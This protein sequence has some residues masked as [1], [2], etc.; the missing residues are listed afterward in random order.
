MGEILACKS[1]ILAQFI[2]ILAF[3]V[4]AQTENVLSIELIDQRILTLRDAGSGDEDETLKAYQSARGLL[5]AAASH[6]REAQEYLDA[7]TNA[8]IREAEILARVDALSEESTPLNFEGLSLNELE[9]KK[10]LLNNKLTNAKDAFDV[11]EKRFSNR[12]KNVLAI[13]QRLSE[14]AE[15]IT[16]LPDEPLIINRDD[17]TS[18]NEASNWVQYCERI[19]LR[20]ERKAQELR[21]DSQSERYSVLQAQRAELKLQIDLFI[22]QLKAVE[23]KISEA[24]LSAFDIS[25]TDIDSHSPIYKIAENII[26]ARSLFRQ[27]RKDL[28]EEKRIIVKKNERLEKQLNAISERLASLRRVVDYA[29]SSEILSSVLIAHWRETESFKLKDPTRELSSTIGDIVI[30]RID[31]EKEESTLF[32][33]RAYVANL[34]ETQK[35]DPELITDE[36]RNSLTN[37]VRSKRTELHELIDEESEYIELLRNHIQIY[38]QLKSLNNEYKNFISSRILWAASHKNI[39]INDF[40]KIPKELKFIYSELTNLRIEKFPFITLLGL[41][42]AIILYLL[43]KHFITYMAKLNKNVATVRND[44]ILFTVNASALTILRALPL[45][46]VFWSL[47]IDFADWEETIFHVLSTRLDLLA[48]IVLILLTIRI[49]CEE[50]GIGLK[51]FGWYKNTTTAAIQE[52]N[53]WLRWWVPLAIIGIIINSLQVDLY[54][55]ITDQLISLLL[56]LLIAWHLFRSLKRDK[57]PEQSVINVLKEHRLKSMFFLLVVIILI[58]LASG[59][60]FT[61][62]KF[63]ET[64][65]YTFIAVIFLV[66]LYN[67]LKR[68]LLITQRKISLSEFLANVEKEKAK[69]DEKNQEEEDRI[70]LVDISVDTQQL[71]KVAV[72]ATSIFILFY[73]WRPLLPAFEILQHVTLWSTTTIINNE[74]IVTAI[75]L[76]SIILGIFIIIAAVYAAGKIPAL[77]ELIL[78]QRVGISASA[79]YTT[80]TLLNYIIIGAGLIIGLSTIGFEWSK[81]QWLVAALGVGIGF[82]LQEIVANFISGLIILFERPIRVGDTVTIGNTDGTIERIRIRATTVV[83]WDGKE[84]LVPNKEFIT[85][86]LLNW[87]LSDSS[88]RIIIKVG[89]AYGSDITKALDILKQILKDHPRVVDDPRPSI[90]FTDFGESSLNL[91]AR[92]FLDSMDNRLGVISE[93]NEIVYKRFKEEGITISFPQRDVHLDS[94]NPIQVRIDSSK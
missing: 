49:I 86:R 25:V 40:K 61:I 15:I 81:L 59:Y 20:A 89:I 27:E 42:I 23:L 78:R 35:I 46:I 56:F 73:I 69:D 33:A 14:I 68:W 19:A 70:T 62:T 31:H 79:S 16:Q 29:A 11:I 87:T 48:L 5:E 93:L 53:W 75:T 94:E 90:I 28:N 10:T 80:S 88:I 91:A 4:N 82:G 52:V 41:F 1:V 92:G 22:K 83:D 39:F 2:L 36:E 64:I 30:N 18:L 67:L 32:N 54:D 66:L 6:E 51:H 74:T 84:L 24:E 9:T 38:S 60:V 77:V 71:L 13:N 50:N 65:L 45:P 57:R 12:E 8:N 85:G 3:S 37:L 34:I 44:S 7:K 72:I 47:S 58:G 26:E 76:Q 43:R 17:A 63:F 21:L 55:N